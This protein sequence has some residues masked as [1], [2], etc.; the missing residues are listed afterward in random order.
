M[1]G[2]RRDDGLSRV[3]ATLPVVAVDE[4]HAARVQAH[5]RRALERNR[6]P[7]RNRASVGDRLGVAARANAVTVA[8]LWASNVWHA[9]LRMVGREQQPGRPGSPVSGSARS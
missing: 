2:E 5:C 9:L 1:S 3:V 6:R 8:M 7:G 4:A